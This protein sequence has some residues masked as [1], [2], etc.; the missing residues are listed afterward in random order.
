M[1]DKFP[2]CVAHWEIV[3]KLESV[4]VV[5]VQLIR[6]LNSKHNVGKFESDSQSIFLRRGYDLANVRQISNYQ[7]SQISSNHFRSYLGCFHAF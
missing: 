3:A 5:W 1:R 4:L 6:Y 7:F 2:E